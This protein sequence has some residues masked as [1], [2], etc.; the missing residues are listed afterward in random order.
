MANHLIRD[1]RTIAKGLPEDPAQ[2]P[3]IPCPT[4]HRGGLTPIA[5]S[6]VLEESETS[7]SWRQHDDWEPDWISGGFHCLLRCRIKDCD[8][9]RVVGRMD[10]TPDYDEFGRW[11]GQYKK[12]LTPEIFSPPLPLI[13]SRDVCT[14]KVGERIDAAAKV[15][16]IDPSS[17][18]NRLR[19]AAEALMDDQG[20]PRKGIDTRGSSRP[21]SLH[22]RINNWKAVKPDY[23][24][25]AELLLAVKWIGNV[26]SHDDRLR[27]ADVL[28]GVE[29]LDHLLTFVYDTTKDEIKK[30]AAEITARKGIPANR[31]HRGN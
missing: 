31:V 22:E 15:I 14:E 28:D 10:L 17:A 12:R 25:P 20:I 5:E 2:W 16:W 30:R 29:I 7:K 1:L 19:S 4:C 24:E 23:T 3:H 9:T 11:Y 8:V 26:G 6:L 27:L 13:E 18:A 21:I